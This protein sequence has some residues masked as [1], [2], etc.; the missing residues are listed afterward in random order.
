MYGGNPWVTAGICAGVVLGL[1]FC[2]AAVVRMVPRAPK[3]NGAN[4]DKKGKKD[5]QLKQVVVHAPAA[6]TP[7]T[8]NSTDSLTSSPSVT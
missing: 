5:T 2:I 8:G 6:A 1:A 4:E 7:K 3:H